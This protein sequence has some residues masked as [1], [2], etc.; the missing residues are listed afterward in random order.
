MTLTKISVTSSAKSSRRQLWFEKI[1]ALLVLLN[2]SLVIFD[3]SYIPLRDFWLQGRVQIYLKI[4]AFER[5][6][7]DP[8]L[9]ILPFPVTQ[10]YD[11]VKGIEAY[12]ETEHYLNLVNQLNDAIEQRITE[13]G[14]ESQVQQI[15]N[16]LEKLRHESVEMIAQNPFQVANKTGTLERIKNKMREHIFDKKDGS[17]KE[18]FT[19]FWTQE[20]F[21]KNGLRHELDFFDEQIRPLIETNYFRPVGENGEPVNNFGLIDLPFFLVFLVEFMA[22]TWSI[23]RRHTGVSWF[24]A[25]LWR[26]YDIFLL[27]PLIRWLRI[28]PLIIRLNQAKLIDMKAIKKQASQGFVAGIAQDITEVVVIQI[29]NQ[30]QSSIEEGS[31]RNLVMRRNV[32]AYIDINDINETAEITKLV[33]HLIVE[34]VLPEIRPE[35][36][37][38]LHYN[39]AKILT[40]TPAYQN[41]E[42]LPGVKSLQT[43]LTQGLVSQLYQSL[44]Q[45]LE[46]LLIEDQKF[47]ELLERLANKFTK[48]MSTEMQCKQSIEQIEELINALLEEVKINYV[49]RLSSEDVEKILEQT[50]ALRQE[51]N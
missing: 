40:Q 3:L 13:P 41:L 5:E 19:I 46:Q 10:Y 43:Q 42:N 44:S 29:I 24:D 37:A 9:K 48:T 39:I 4:G 14:N 25:M 51:I 32:N 35:A 50:R 33:A 28:I 18:A 38:F 23:S 15:E 11:W 47:N 6:I 12:R 36:E 17:A 20:N 34:K 49:Q 16:L 31:I 2:Y 7:P 8:P 26:W 45:G 27:I 22:R 30:V 21:Q 1:M